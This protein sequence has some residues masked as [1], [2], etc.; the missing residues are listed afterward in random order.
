ML[1]VVLTAFAFIRYKKRCFF[2]F[3]SRICSV[4]LKICFLFL[5]SRFECLSCT[6]KIQKI[7]RG[8]RRSG[9]DAVTE[10]EPSFFCVVFDGLAKLLLF[11][12]VF[13][14]LLP[15]LELQTGRKKKTLQKQKRWRCNGSWSLLIT[16]TFVHGAMVALESFLL[17]CLSRCFCVCLGFFFF[18]L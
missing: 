15:G 2:I 7:H 13:Y 1:N 18:F 16:Q 12:G 17:W 14:V 3:F 6:T 4:V 11:F 9:A 5:T 10:P 8:P